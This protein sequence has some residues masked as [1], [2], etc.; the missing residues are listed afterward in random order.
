MLS[1][2]DALRTKRWL[3]DIENDFASPE[4][5]S[6]Y[7]RGVI[8]SKR[9]KL[10]SYEEDAALNNRPTYIPDPK[11]TVENI[12]YYQ[13]ASSEGGE[14]Y[15]GKDFQLYDTEEKRAEIIAPLYISDLSGIDP[16]EVSSKLSSYKQH[17]MN[18]HGVNNFAT[19]LQMDM[20][21]TNE[22]S[23]LISEL[24]QHASD[25]SAKAVSS[26]LMD[27]GLDQFK[28]MSEFIDSKGEDFTMDK[29]MSDLYRDS[30]AKNLEIYQRN[31]E[32]FEKLS[33]LLSEATED[34]LSPSLVARSALALNRIDPK[35]RGH[36]LKYAE[37]QVEG[38]AEGLKT[39]FAISLEATRKKKSGTDYM[40]VV[41]KVYQLSSDMAKGEDVE[42]LR[43]LPL[44]TGNAFTA[45]ANVSS[46]SR[47]DGIRILSRKA[48]GEEKDQLWRDLQVAGEYA[49]SIDAIEEFV[50]EKTTDVSGLDWALSRHIY[51]K[52]LF[53]T[54]ESLP[55][56]VE[57]GS[58][59]VGGAGIGAGMKAVGIGSKLLR[60][61]VSIA[62]KT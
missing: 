60:G 31:S 48:T 30:Y 1:D 23:S 43:G 46:A 26:P 45:I 13:N 25:A 6:P 59:A 56:M 7:M 52:M 40:D 47:S 62:L 44:K 24:Y 17:Y 35:M 34:T 18:K 20:E 22:K 16:S 42:V 32:S 49:A 41:E 12:P 29:E 21:Q 51:D 5:I 57:Y 3:E 55:Y 58:Y 9:G 53:P 61:G 33:G 4:L 54:L 15:F 27:G 37:M 19:A 14:K 39:L 38:G 11:K 2:N 36:A 50:R 28:A 10:S 8:D